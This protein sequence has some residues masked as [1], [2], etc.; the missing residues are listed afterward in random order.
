MPH[1][2]LRNRGW[3]A[4]Q[5]AEFQEQVL[6]LGRVRRFGRGA[7]VYSVGD[8]PG[9]IF[10]ILQGVLA[11]SIAPGATGPHLAH[12]ARPGAWF[13][14]GAFLTGEPRRIGLLALVDSVLFHL[15]LDAMERLADGDPETMRRFG[16]IAM[17]N[18]DLCLHAINDLL[19]A[20]PVARIAATLLRCLGDEA[21]GRVTISQAELGRL[22]NASR[23]VV[24]RALRALAGAGLVQVRYAEIAVLD[25]GALAD[26][27]AE[28]ALLPRPGRAD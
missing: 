14:E 11:I 26:F 3:L 9:G 19:I 6:A 15:P 20:D 28:G 17:G 22:S 13:G 24:N 4:R 16:Q 21:S 25:P 12:F 23:K 10:G 2:I 8:P 5:P 1:D 7:M 18:I 27:A